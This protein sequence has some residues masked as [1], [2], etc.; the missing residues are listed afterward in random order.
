[1][2]V[3]R[4]EVQMLAQEIISKKC[5][6]IYIYIYI[7]NQDTQF[8]GDLLQS[9]LHCKPAIVKNFGDVVDEEYQDEEALLTLEENLA[10]QVRRALGHKLGQQGKKLAKSVSK[11]VKSKKVKSKKVI[12]QE[13]QQ[14][15]HVPEGQLVPAEPA[16]RKASRG[17]THMV[18]FGPFEL[19]YLRSGADADRKHKHTHT[20]THTHTKH[21]HAHTP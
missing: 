21:P 10:A 9:I 11:K 13:R 19:K 20:H 17:D 3:S 1:M 8:L 16:P 12:G 15:D 2:F 18:H 14:E 7:Y 6:Y 4:G 5:I